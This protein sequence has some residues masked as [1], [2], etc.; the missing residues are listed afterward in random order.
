M[1]HKYFQT[2]GLTKDASEEEIKKAYRKLAMEWHP[3]KNPHRMEEAE[4]KFKEIGEAYDYLMDGQK[5]AEYVQ[6]GDRGPPPPPPFMNEFFQFH[7]T[8]SVPQ[9]KK[10]MGLSPVD[11]HIEVTLEDIYQNVK[12]EILWKRNRICSHCRHFT[13]TNC[14]T[15]HGSGTETMRRQVGPFFQQIQRPCTSCHGYG[16]VTQQYCNKC[17]GSETMEETIV[18]KLT[19]P[20]GIFTGDFMMVPNEGHEQEDGTFTDLKVI[21][22]V[23]PHAKFER[24][25]NNLY[26]VWNITLYDALMGFQKEW[27]HLSGETYWIAQNGIT[28]YHK[29]YVVKGKGMKGKDGTW[30]DC[31]ISFDYQMPEEKEIEMIRGLLKEKDEMNIPVGKPILKMESLSQPSMLFQQNWKHQHEETGNTANASCHIQ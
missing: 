16:K 19:I 21:F 6:W 23:Q 8:T 15:C 13:K 31:Y 27:T 11:F 25:E 14:P 12:K 2:L 22:H 26:T 5:R 30:G 18:K 29:L 3:D 17:S 9:P 1:T 4:K 7:H 28:D 24:R 20:S 10:R